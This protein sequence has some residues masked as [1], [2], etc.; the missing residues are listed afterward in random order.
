MLLWDFLFGS[1][2][3]WW[4]LFLIAAAAFGGLRVAWRAWFR[5]RR[6]MAANM[7]RLSDSR[8]AEARYTLAVVHAES[9]RWKSS[10][11]LIEEAI[12]ITSSDSRYNHVPH[13]FLRL[14]ADCLYRL[15]EWK[16]AVDAYHQALAVP[17]ETGYADALLGVARSQLRAGR[18]KEAVAFSRHAIVE[19]ESRLEAYYR[20]AQAA[21]AGGDDAETARAKSEFRRVAALLPPFARQK[22]MWWRFAFMT[23]PISRRIG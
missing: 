16:A 9:K 22:R 13:R 21:S 10:K 19:H 2:I 8:N 14:R 23:F 6:G 17:S 3:G 5:R 11:A 18:W 4:I 20:W 12:A 7:A 1:I 15:R